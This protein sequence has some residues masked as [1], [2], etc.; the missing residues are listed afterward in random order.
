MKSGIRI[1]HNRLLGGWFIVRGPHQT[2]LGGKFPSREAALEHLRNPP[3]ATRQRFF[4]CPQCE[5]SFPERSL[6][7]G[8]MPEHSFLRSRCPG[9]GAQ[10]F[11]KNPAAPDKELRR[12]M[13]LRERF[14]GHVSGVENHPKPVV[15]D[16]LVAIGPVLG[17]MYEAERDGVKEKYIHE[18]RA[19]QSRPLLTASPDGSS[20]WLL[21]GAYHF[22]KYGILDKR[23]PK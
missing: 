13:K 15:P 4:S 3:Q 12:A 19:R 18:F 21:G 1:V 17:I 22:T 16:R 2:P 5:A 14:S 7:A 8:K 6:V 9:S 10:V 23:R 11:Q 20:L